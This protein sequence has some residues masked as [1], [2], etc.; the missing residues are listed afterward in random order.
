[1]NDVVPVLT[2]AGC[3]AG[4]CMRKP[5]AGRTAFNCRCWVFEPQDDFENLVKESRNRRLFLG[6]P[7]RSLLLLKASARMPHGGG[8]AA[9]CGLRRLCRAARLDTQGARYDAKAARN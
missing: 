3:N 5:A 9:G 8:R 6:A 2:K 4:V 7:E 1:M